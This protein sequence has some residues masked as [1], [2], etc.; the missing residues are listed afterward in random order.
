MNVRVRTC[1]RIY[2]REITKA[3]RDGFIQKEVFNLGLKNRLDL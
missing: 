2:K 1:S 3:I